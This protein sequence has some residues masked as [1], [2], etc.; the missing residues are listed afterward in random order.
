MNDILEIGMRS[1]R[2]PKLPKKGVNAQIVDTAIANGL[3]N[4]RTDLR[5]GLI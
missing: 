1:R 4:A 2:N 5:D 3:N